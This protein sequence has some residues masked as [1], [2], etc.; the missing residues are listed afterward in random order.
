VTPI[1]IVRVGIDRLDELVEFWLRLHEYQ[2]SVADPVEGVDLLSDEASGA[3]VRDMYREWLSDA[4]SFAFFAEADGLPVGYVV[5][6]YDEPHFMW[7]TGRIGHIDS[8]YVLPELRGRGVGRL[9]MD[10]TYEEM[11][12]AGVTT[13]VLEM[14]ATNQLARLFYEREGFTTTFV[15]MLRRL[16]PGEAPQQVQ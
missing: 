1:T 5:A 15:Q 16:P 13:V 10:R 14:I 11:R 6:F 12:G 3:V 8:F 2:G 4:D 9:L 7:D